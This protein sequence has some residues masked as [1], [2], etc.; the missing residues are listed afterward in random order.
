MSIE[1]I[2]ERRK[3][4][5][6]NARALVGIRAAITN[7]YLDLDARKHG[8]VAM[9]L[10]FSKIERILGMSWEDHKETVR[11]VTQLAP[12]KAMELHNMFQDTLM[13]TAYRGA[14]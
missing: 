9:D 5:D 7:Y 4:P 12:N 14:K 2:P 13:T 1:D 3:T 6:E 10:A 11:E 8:S